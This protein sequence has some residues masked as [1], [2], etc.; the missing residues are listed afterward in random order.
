[1][2]G[3]AAAKAWVRVQEPLHGLV[4]A[5]ED[6]HHVRAVVL[7]FGQE[8]RDGVPGE[9]VAPSARPPVVAD[10]RVGFIEKQ[11]AAPCSRE[12]LDHLGRGLADVLA[13]ELKGVALHKGVDAKHSVGVQ[14]LVQDPR[15]RGLAHARSPGQHEVSACVEDAPRAPSLDELHLADEL[16]HVGLGLCEP[17]HCLELGHRLSFELLLGLAL[18][19]PLRFRCRFN[20]PPGI[21]LLA[22]LDRFFRL[23]TVVGFGG[24]FGAVGLRVL[25]HCRP[26]RLADLEVSGIEFTACPGSFGVLGR[27]QLHDPIHSRREPGGRLL[28]HPDCQAAV[29]ARDFRGIDCAEGLGKAGAQ[30]SLEAQAKGGEGAVLR[31]AREFRG[32]V[33]GKVERVRKAARKARIRTKHGGHLVTV[34]SKDDQDAGSVVFD[35]GE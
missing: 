20:A 1:M 9:A 30:A 4:V 5:G 14:N 34:P 27:P 24:L 11:G 33:V 32:R 8:G 7:R 12:G 29:V 18:G 3:K 28:D 15:E 35:L 25:V 21:T 6:H 26:H 22:F 10:E 23:G 19:F 13:L 31:D 16:C 2:A 17:N